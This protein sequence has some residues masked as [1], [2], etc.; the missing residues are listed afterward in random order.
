MF[1]H[2][3]S[4]QDQETRGGA[5]PRYTLESPLSTSLVRTLANFNVAQDAEDKDFG[6]SYVRTTLFVFIQCMPMLPYM[7]CFLPDSR[8]LI[9][10]QQQ[11]HFAGA[12][13]K[14]V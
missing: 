9:G 5:M 10:S 12:Q 14:L 6:N 11:R 7:I 2:L 8:C 4:K 1:E 3:I 13:L